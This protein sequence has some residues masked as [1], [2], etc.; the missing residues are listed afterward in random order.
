LFNPNIFLGAGAISYEVNV[1]VETLSTLAQRFFN[2]FGFI[3]NN[4]FNTTN[5]VYF[6]YDEGGVITGNP[7]GSANWKCVTISASTRTFTTTSVAVTASAWVKLRIEIN[8][9]ATSVGFYIN[10]VLVATHTTNIPTSS[11]PICIYNLHLKQTGLTSL[12]TYID[13]IAYRKIFTSTR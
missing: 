9:A 4:S 3:G 10:D 2:M 12:T 8:A 1:N 7:S 13:Y 6:L 11:A 5:G